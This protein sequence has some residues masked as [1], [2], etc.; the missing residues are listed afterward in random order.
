MILLNV[1]LSVL[2]LVAVLVMLYMLAA[3]SRRL[4]EVTKMRPYYRG[5]YLAMAGLALAIG[6]A[7]LRPP[8]GPSDAYRIAYYAPLTLAALISL[9][10][11]LRYWGWLF[12]ERRK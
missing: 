10:V 9:V 3:L 5:F 12:R 6:V 8:G 2:G 11:A 4:G 1:P 7:L